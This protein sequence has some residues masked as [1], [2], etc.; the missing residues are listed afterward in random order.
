MLFLQ[1]W[2]FWSI[3]AR[4]TEFYLFES[5]MHHIYK[6]IVLMILLSLPVSAVAYDFELDG[7][8]YVISDSSAMVT[9]GESPYSGVVNIPETVVHQGNTYQETMPWQAHFGTITER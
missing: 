3:F 9:S 5:V 2:R 1:K 4:K 8:Y 6:Y 7:V